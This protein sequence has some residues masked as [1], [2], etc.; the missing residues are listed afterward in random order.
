MRTTACYVRQRLGTIAL[1]VVLAVP[2]AIFM[3]VADASTVGTASVNASDAQV[4]V[5]MSPVRVLDTR[6]APYGP[7]GTP[8]AQKLG[9]N[10]TINL[11]LAGSTRPL[12]SEAVAAV[13]N[14]TI[15][16]DSTEKSYLTIWPQG[17][18]RPNTSANNAEPGLVV[19]NSMIAKL[20]TN[21]GISIYNLQGAV[22]VV[23]DLVG[24][25][26]PVDQVTGL[27][28]SHFLVGATP[29]NAGTGVNGDMY[30]D[31]TT[32]NLYGPK[33]GG[34]WGAPVANLTGP[35]G[36]GG[37]GVETSTSTPTGA[38]SPNGLLH[39]NITTGEMVVCQS[40][41]WSAVLNVRNTISGATTYGDSGNSPTSIDLSPSAY[42][43]VATFTAPATGQY[44]LD[45]VANIAQEDAVLL[46]VLA[47]VRC[48]WFD[49]AG[50]NQLGPRSGVSTQAQ[51]SLVG[52]SNEVTLNATAKTSLTGAATATL[53]CQ[54]NGTLLG[55]GGYVATGWSYQATRVA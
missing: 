55:L 52:L 15:D 44:I 53:R 19:A 49:G 46:G 2:S 4:L 45:G 22:N 54:F 51:V 14:I 23:I 29:P 7:I 42:T 48:A 12:P 9:K 35:P 21:G 8:I 20:G 24:Y 16:D 28:G 34:A 43:T 6:P 18:A 31:T 13:I 10:A 11:P 47:T 50:A 26:L 41:T 27:G 37:P 36:P 38:C 30:F 33:A 1:I 5:A 32:K 39:I 17:E 40:G 3:A 25:L